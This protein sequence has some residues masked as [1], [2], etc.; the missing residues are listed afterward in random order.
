MPQYSETAEAVRDHDSV[1]AWL[2]HGSAYSVLPQWR[3]GRERVRQC[4]D[5][6]AYVYGVEL[7]GEPAEPVIVGFSRVAVEDKGVL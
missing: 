5:H 4:G 7:L 3:V 6:G 2:A 1:L